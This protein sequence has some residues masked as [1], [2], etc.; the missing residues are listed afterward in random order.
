[1]KV[2]K[3]CCTITVDISNYL[4]VLSFDSKVIIQRGSEIACVKKTCVSNNPVQQFYNMTNPLKEEFVI[5][6]MFSEFAL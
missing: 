6:K 2:V 5:Y 3:K 1:M 4:L